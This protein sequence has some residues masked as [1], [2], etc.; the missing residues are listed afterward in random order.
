MEY[1]HFR[2]Q[3]NLIIDNVFKS[4]HRFIIRELIDVTLWNSLEEK[5]RQ[6]FGSNFREDVR[7]GLINARLSEQEDNLLG[8]AI[9]IK[10]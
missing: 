8:C 5:T 3:A 7:Q 1:E 2:G 4:G 9:Y 10:K 6:T